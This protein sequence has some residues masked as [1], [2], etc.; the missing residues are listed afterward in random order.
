M[1]ISPTRTHLAPSYVPTGGAM[2]RKVGS[3][4]GDCAVN[5]TQ[6][7]STETGVSNLSSSSSAAADLP[8][9]SHFHLVSVALFLKW[10]ACIGKFPRPQSSECLQRGT[11]VLISQQEFRG[12]GT[13]DTPHP[14]P[15]AKGGHFSKGEVVSSLRHFLLG[16]QAEK[17]PGKG[18]LPPSCTAPSWVISSLHPQRRGKFRALLPSDSAALRSRS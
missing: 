15:G 7:R 1:G 2:N 9:E 12:L 10:G 17:V 13:W 18:G 4:H 6:W 3:S 8:C 14:F 16:T 11:Q 5:R